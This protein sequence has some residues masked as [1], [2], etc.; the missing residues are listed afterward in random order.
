[1]MCNPHQTLLADKT[2]RM[3]WVGHVTRIGVMRGAYRVLVESSEGNRPLGRSG[4]K[5]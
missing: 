2:R 3:M 1:M 4:F 5:L